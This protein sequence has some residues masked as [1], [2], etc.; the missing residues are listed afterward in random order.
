MSE[1]FD[2]AERDRFIIGH[3]KNI[4]VIAPAGVGKTHVIVQRIVGI[5]RLPAE[6]AA[7]RLARLV[8]VTY[9]V[10][11]ALQMQERAR[12]AI[13]AAGV[14][15]TV[16]RAFQ[17]TF[18]GTIHSYC[19]QLL[20]RFGH[21]L[22]L[23][24]PFTLL[25]NQSEWWNRFLVRGVGGLE[26]TEPMRELF[27][28]FTPDKLYGLGREV[29]P[30]VEEKISAGP[31]LDVRPLLRFP[32]G[33]LH[34]SMRTR[35]TRAQEEVKNWN[36]AWVRGDR[37]F[38]LPE[39]PDSKNAEFVQLWH[40]TF[41]PLH[42]W[43]GEAAH[44]FGRQVANAYETFRLGEAAMTYDD[45]V[46]LAERLLDLREVQAELAEE[47]NSVLLDE[48]QDTDPRQFQVLLRVAGIGPHLKQSPEQSFCIVGDFQQAIYVPR[49]D[50]SIYQRVH[51]SLIAQP[52]GD[53][54]RF[55]VTFRCDRSII[56]F[57]NE[58]FPTVLHGE[59]GQS[60]FFILR[61]R[62]GA[63]EGQVVRWGCP[64][65]TPDPTLRPNAE[66]RARHE[67]LFLAREIKRLAYAGLGADGWSQVAILCPRRN[68][69]AQIYR[70]LLALE[71]PAQLHSG[72]DSANDETGVV[73]LTSLIWIAAHPEDSFEI[74]G[75][76]REI[77]GVSDHDMATFTRGDGD[78]LRLDRELPKDANPVA[79]VLALL[80]ETIRDASIFPVHLVIRRL[81]EKTHLRQRVR[82]VA[83]PEEEADAGIEDL[84]AKIMRRAA[85]GITLAG[86]ALELRDGLLQPS[87]V[88][89][90]ISDSIQLMTS[91]K[92]KGLEWQTVI[93]PYFFRAI[94]SPKSAY[95][96]VVQGPGD[97][98]RIFRDKMHYASSAQAFVTE[99]DRQQ[100]QR[101]LYVACTRARHTLLLIDDEALFADQQKRGGSSSG[102]LLGFTQD[103]NRAI[104][105]ALPEKIVGTPAPLE[106]FS[107][108]QMAPPP[109]PAVFRFDLGRSLARAKDIPRRITPHALAIKPP[110]ES[111]LEPRFEGEEAA[112]VALHPGLIYGTWWHEF[113]QAVPWAES[114][115]RWQ[116]SFEMA[117]RQ[118][119]QPERSRREW[120]LF[121]V[122]RL[123]A[124]LAQP[125]LLVQPEVPFLWAENSE[126]CLEGVIDL[127]VRVPEENGWRVI[128]WK[129]NSVSEGLVEMYRGQIEAYVR[130]MERM[131]GARARGSLYLTATG[132]WLDVD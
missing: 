110:V 93:I 48:A 29:A 80:R 47:R 69:L 39:C 124:F 95:P 132:E 104:F 54:S 20:G 61:P 62:D 91:H 74:A 99:R 101:L 8:V 10:R 12:A 33:G 60:K 83:A 16:Q 14:S 18:F 94:E 19:V 25:Q 50:L 88:E 102:E 68:W 46:R 59:N 131:L 32:L 78:R 67:A 87:P 125:N 116:E 52:R 64:E 44:A 4:S 51:D 36:E 1:L 105:H 58:V 30:G 71:L 23:P 34:A 79:T 21:Y 22:G 109:S 90:E 112:P 126:Q 107:P 9:S 55:E 37:F 27:H 128:D 120:E 103:P 53:Q 13:R 41:S 100:Y 11:A 28:F 38:P 3:G 35:L 73:W 123:A 122:S 15:A 118:S 111:E 97:N 75:V 66:A 76:L 115:A 24:S 40:E 77:F 7:D 119:P 86:L 96:R 130:A 43:L 108:R 2:Q 114:R 127:A 121:L 129:T 85:E 49:S 81:V 98:E 45:Q 57:V 26:P 31:A 65:Q 92:A 72:A 42:D 17:Q 63:G 117:Q 106:L 89:A 70:E 113:V 82:S 56:R 84:L 5:A 6:M